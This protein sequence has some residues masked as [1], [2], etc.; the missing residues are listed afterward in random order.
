MTGKKTLMH[1]MLTV[2]MEMV[3]DN[4][5]LISYGAMYLMNKM[6]IVTAVIMG[7]AAIASGGDGK[8]CDGDIGITLTCIC[9]FL[10]CVLGARVVS[11]AMDNLIEKTKARKKH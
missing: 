6:L 5:T 1:G 11:V 8:Y 10:L 3:E 9:A 4:I 2:E 7:L